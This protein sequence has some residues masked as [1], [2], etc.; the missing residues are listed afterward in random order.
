MQK[1]LKVY[2]VFYG[3]VAE[4]R[5]ILKNSSIKTMLKNLAKNLKVT[6]LHF[7][8]VIISLD[9]VNSALSLREGIF[10]YCWKTFFHGKWWY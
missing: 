3:A 7:D 1:Y 8:S 2:I 5:K 6:K 10:I 9:A 4:N